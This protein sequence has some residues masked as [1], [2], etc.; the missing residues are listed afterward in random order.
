MEILRL[1]PRRLPS[2]LNP[3]AHKSCEVEF[4]LR[5]GR[6]VHDLSNRARYWIRKL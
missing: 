5:R 3:L 2:I 4:D 6:R 1:K